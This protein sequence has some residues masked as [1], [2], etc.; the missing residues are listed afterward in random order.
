ML[1]A[2]NVLGVENGDI[3]TMDANLWK[4]LKIT[5]LGFL[6]LVGLQV[7]EFTLVATCTVDLKL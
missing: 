2:L 5:V 6:W 1:I 3:K 4:Q 7:V